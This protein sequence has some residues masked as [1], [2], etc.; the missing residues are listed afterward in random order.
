MELYFTKNYFIITMGVLYCVSL[1][2]QEDFNHFFNKHTWDPI[3]LD[4]VEVNAKCTNCPYVYFPICADD[5][6]TYINE[7][8]LK[9][10]NKNK[11]NKSQQANFVRT[12]PCEVFPI[13]EDK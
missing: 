7:C 4:E 5:N 2:T 9:C 6:K 3:A 10:K 8:K 12:G 11:R 13:E 1:V